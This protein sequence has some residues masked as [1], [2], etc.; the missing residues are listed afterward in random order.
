[1]TTQTILKVAPGKLVSEAGYL[2]EPSGLN[3]MAQIP[4]K[5][6]S[7]EVPRTKLEH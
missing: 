7:G 1:M 4:V 5:I 3:Q 6:S 2:E